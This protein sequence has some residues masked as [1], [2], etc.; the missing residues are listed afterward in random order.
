MTNFTDPSTLPPDVASK[1]L[2][3]RD[4]L[5]GTPESEPDFYEAYHQLYSIACPAFGCRDPWAALEAVVEQDAVVKLDG[6]TCR[7][8]NALEDLKL[9][10][11][12][13]MREELMG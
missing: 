4:A 11:R 10:G 8:R 6:M 7:L 12:W 3:I 13:S 2:A 9:N 1:L 5:V